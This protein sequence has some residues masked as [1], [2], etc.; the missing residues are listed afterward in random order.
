VDEVRFQPD[1]V[2]TEYESA[3]EA[4]HKAARAAAALI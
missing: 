3:R 1:L 2:T 4:A